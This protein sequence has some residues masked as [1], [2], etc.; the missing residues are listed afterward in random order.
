MTNYFPKKD[1]FRPFRL[2]PRLFIVPLLF[3]DELV[4]AEKGLLISV[5]FVI[6]FP[7]LPSS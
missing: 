6:F 4:T 2:L 1:L 7:Y 5:A 3:W